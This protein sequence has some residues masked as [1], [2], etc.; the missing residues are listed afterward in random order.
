MKNQKLDKAL[1]KVKNYDL[2]KYNKR[3]R[4]IIDLIMII[5]GILWIVFIISIFSSKEKLDKAKYVE[6]IDGDTFK[7]K[8]NYKIE[9]V[10]LL[11]VIASNN[12]YTCNLI[13]NA[14]SIT[15]KYEKNKYNDENN[16][17]AWVYVDKKLIQELLLEKSFAKLDDNKYE[18]T[19]ELKKII[20]N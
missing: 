13:K 9:T 18:I 17:L 19:K 14:K 2:S 20:T 5:I 3:K 8:I 12:E 4:I 1:E 10:E 7:L 11:N 15:L 6:C 16:L